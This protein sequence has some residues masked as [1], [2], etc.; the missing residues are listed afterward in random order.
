MIFIVNVA[1][2]NSGLESIVSI[3]A[4]SRQQAE[5]RLSELGLYYRKMD[6]NAIFR[7]SPDTFGEAI[8]VS[9]LPKKIFLL[10]RSDSKDSFV[11]VLHISQDVHSFAMAWQHLFDLKN[12][13]NR[14]AV[15]YPYCQVNTKQFIM[16]R[17]V[18]KGAVQ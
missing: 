13:M 15:E 1:E 12:W 2:K 5:Q 18:T 14:Q 8:T 16:A 9:D 10:G 11:M 6:E 3:E 7:I 17:V 4:D